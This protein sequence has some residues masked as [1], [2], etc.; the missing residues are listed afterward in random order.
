[1]IAEIRR[2][3]E[4]SSRK[5]FQVSTPPVRYWLM[6]DVLG[7]GPEDQML[8]KTVEECETYP[9][10]VRLLQLLREDGTWP[11]P[12]QKKEEEE[13]GP[14]PPVGW[15]YITMLRNQYSL[16]DYVANKTDGLI[17]ASLERMLSWQSDEG[18]IPG[19]TMLSLPEPHYNGFALRNLNQFR[20]DR[21]PRT[22]RLEQW[23][24]SMQRRDGG[25][26]IPYIQDVR[27]LPKYRHMRMKDFMRLIQSDE[28]PPYDP[29]EYEDIPS[30]IWSTLTVLRGFYWSPSMRH[31]REIRRGS[32]F[33]LDRLFKRNYHSSFYQSEKNWTTLKYP[34]HLGSG[35]SALEVLATVG[36]GPEDERME[37]AVRWLLTARSKDGFW[38]RSGRPSAEN[39][40]WITEIAL[41]ILVRYAGMYGH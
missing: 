12:A 2:V 31:R 35:L 28:R 25:W 24:L 40:Q 38:Y 29:E 22:Y 7:K 33:I 36:Y 6:K 27:Y 1:M 41:S 16:G 11:I 19:P 37:R 14:G 23:L 4:E 17:G 10:R 26:L 30:C 18:F 13:R 9:P 20:M 8:R 21:D 34:T 32:D 39:D 3:V 15:T 5:L